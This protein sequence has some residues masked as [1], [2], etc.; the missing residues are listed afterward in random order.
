MLCVCAC[1]SVCVLKYTPI[2]RKT[3]IHYRHEFHLS[4]Q[5]FGFIFLA[6]VFSIT[7]PPHPHVVVWLEWACVKK[8]VCWWRMLFTDWLLVLLPVVGCVHGVRNVRTTRAQS[9]R[10]AG[11]LWTGCSKGKSWSLKYKHCTRWWSL[12]TLRPKKVKWW[13][14]GIDNVHFSC[15][16]KLIPPQIALQYKMSV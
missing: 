15:T 3:E 16:V 10:H 1:T 9:A 8:T 4:C 11:G 6:D 7:P 2:C 12:R 5:S 14:G 13:T